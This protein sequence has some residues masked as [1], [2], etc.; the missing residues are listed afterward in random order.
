MQQKARDEASK[1]LLKVNRKEEARKEEQETQHLTKQ[2]REFQL[3]R[4]S[5]V[6]SQQEERQLLTPQRQLTS[7]IKPRSTQSER[8]ALRQAQRDMKPYICLH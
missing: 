7:G 4:V 6:V 2:V 3:R 1:L 5:N 8:R